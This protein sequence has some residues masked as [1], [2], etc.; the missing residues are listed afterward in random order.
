MQE[1]MVCFRLV[2]VHVHVYNFIIT[3]V[4]HVICVLHS[5]LRKLH[6]AGPTGCALGALLW[7]VVCP[8]SPALYPCVELL[9]TC[10]RKTESHEARLEGPLPPSSRVTLRV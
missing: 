3:L 5:Q 6:R 9:L 10:I 2:H 4:W 1:C 8:L 7:L